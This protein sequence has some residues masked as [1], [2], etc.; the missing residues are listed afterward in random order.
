M[1]NKKRLKYIAIPFFMVMG[2]AAL[3]YIVMVLWN[4]AV[5]GAINV[6][7]EITYWQ[8][9]ALL[10]LSKILFGFGM[11]GRNKH[12]STWFKEKHFTPEQKEAFKQKWESHCK[13]HDVAKEP[14]E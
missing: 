10:I 7:N 9:M 8:A 6:V 3:S 4:Y 12:K 1:K 11:N 13:N 5:V 14:K 2:L